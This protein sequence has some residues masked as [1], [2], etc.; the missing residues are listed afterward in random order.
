MTS[1]I[2]ELLEMP[3]APVR[4]GELLSLIERSLADGKG[5]WIVT[6]NLDILRYFV[7]DAL[8]RKAYLA[9]DL[10]VADGAP[11]VW[12]A[13][14]AGSPLPERVAGSSLCVPLAEL[15]ARRGYRLAL[16]GGSPTSAERAADE[17]RR[18][19]AALNIEAESNLRF[20][21]PPSSEEIA[22]A[23]KRFAEFVPDV[24]LVGLGSPKQEFVIEQ[25][26]EIWPSAWFIGVGGSF[27]FIA[28]DVRRAPTFMQHAGLEWVHR[29]LLEPRRL[30]PRYLGH[31]LPLGV[32]LLACALKQ[33]L[34][35]F[36]SH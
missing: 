5:G 29:M 2:V 4:S 19:C 32:R 21:G 27:S 17:L 6:A 12:A 22:V 8:A 7:S 31:D 34:S 3:L 30:G 15:C 20:S 1:A 25:L 14:L 10:R 11:L 24:V 28:G 35:R 23:V 36:A 9:A 18:R 16:V 13:A 26:R 33:R